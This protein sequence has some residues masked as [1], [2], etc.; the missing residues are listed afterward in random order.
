MSVG[1]E[2]AERTITNLAAGRIA[3]D[4]TDGINGS[5]LFAT[6]QAVEAIDTEVGELTDRAVK[7]DGT[8]GDPK[9]LITL[10]GDVSSDGGLTGGTRITNLSQG[11]GAVL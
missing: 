3:A 7:Y 6:N 5:Q 8:T 2:G 10:E 9:D 1:S 4:S 11:V